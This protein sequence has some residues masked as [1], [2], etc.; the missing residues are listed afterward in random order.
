M[1]LNYIWTSSCNFSL[2]LQAFIPGCYR[3]EQFHCW[4]F[5]PDAQFRSRQNCRKYSTYVYFFSTF[6]VRTESFSNSKCLFKS[7]FTPVLF[8]SV[9]HTSTLAISARRPTNFFSSRLATK[10]PYVRKNSNRDIWLRVCHICERGDTVRLLS[11]HDGDKRLIAER[12]AKLRPV[13]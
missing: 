6:C 12:C 11:S 4:L 13:Q 3:C 8:A 1:I 10:A 5:F 2:L 9:V 7:F